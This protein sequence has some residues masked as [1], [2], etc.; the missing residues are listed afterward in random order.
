MLKLNGYYLNNVYNVN[1]LFGTVYCFYF[2]E[3]DNLH[4]FTPPILDGDEADD[5]KYDSCEEFYEDVFYI[6][7]A[8]LKDE[9]HYN[10]VLKSELR[11]IRGY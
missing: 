4:C 11:R 3:N 10:Q 9:T 2:D 7:L 8:W 5:K 1:I 6:F